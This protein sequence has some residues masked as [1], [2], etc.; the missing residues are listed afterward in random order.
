M[1]NSFF[2]S[3]DAPLHAPLSVAGLIRMANQRVHEDEQGLTVR[4]SSAAG[5]PLPPVAPPLANE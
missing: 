4:L 2:C 3:A 5:M 1:K